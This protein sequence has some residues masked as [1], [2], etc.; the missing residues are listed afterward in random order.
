[1]PD[2]PAAVVAARDAWQESVDLLLRYA[3]D[4]LVPAKNHHVM[5]TEVYP[6]FAQWLKANGHTVWSD[7]LF[8]ARLAQHPRMKAKGV[9]KKRV[10]K[11]TQGQTLS[12]RT[13]WSGGNPVTGPSDKYSAWVGVRFRTAIDTFDPDGKNG[14]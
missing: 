3:C 14:W 7:Q 11:S 12:R 10:S 1:M 8:A 9:T 13:L 4:N 5:S 6:D 2:P